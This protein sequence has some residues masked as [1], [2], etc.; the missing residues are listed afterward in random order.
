MSELKYMD[1]SLEET[2]KNLNKCR[3]VIADQEESITQFR[4]MILTASNK[5]TTNKRKT[6]IFLAGAGRSGF[7]QRHSP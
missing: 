1:L 2:L 5:R 4:D 6:T 3:D 7:L